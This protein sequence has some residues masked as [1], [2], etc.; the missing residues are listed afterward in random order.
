MDLKNDKAWEI[1]FLLFLFK[2]TW[3][4]KYTYF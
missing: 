4:I 1:K 2:D 3:M